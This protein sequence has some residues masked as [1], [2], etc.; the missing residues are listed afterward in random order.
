MA[1]KSKKKKV[2]SVKSVKSSSPNL[3]RRL[4][5]ALRNFGLFLIMFLVSWGLYSASETDLMINLFFLLSVL[6]GFVTLAFL[7]V[8]LIFVFMKVMS[9]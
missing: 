3:K 9:K 1:K 7:L 8:L 6:F 5:I 2:Q 4:G